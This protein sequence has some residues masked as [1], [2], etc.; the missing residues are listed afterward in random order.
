VRKPRAWI[1]AV[2]DSGILVENIATADAG[3]DLVRDLVCKQLC[4]ATA[5]AI[6]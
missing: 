4:A 1:D 6:V 3:D 2:D 5:F